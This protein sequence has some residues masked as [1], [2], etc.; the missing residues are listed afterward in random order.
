MQVKD[1]F[2]SLMHTA[3]GSQGEG[4][5]GSETEGREEGGESLSMQLLVCNH[6]KGWQCMDMKPTYFCMKFHCQHKEAYTCRLD[7]CYPCTQHWGHRVKVCRGQ[8]L[9]EGREEC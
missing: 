1:V 2:P 5:Q 8:E 7:F 3:L 9:W 4:V 6:Y